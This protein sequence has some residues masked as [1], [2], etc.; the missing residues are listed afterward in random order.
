MK[1]R[2]SLDASSTAFLIHWR[3][4]GGSICADPDSRM[5]LMQD[6]IAEY[7]S[8]KV[9]N[10]RI[11]RRIITASRISVASSWITWMRVTKSPND[12]NANWKDIANE[13]VV[14]RFEA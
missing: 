6:I 12:P 9:T 14:S 13:R 4:S 8:R 10:R 7:S 1:L 3:T 11:S 5:P 2:T